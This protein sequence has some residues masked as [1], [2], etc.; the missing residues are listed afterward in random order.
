MQTVRRFLDGVW[1]FQFDP[2]G[3]A[4]FS[5]SDPWRPAIVPS[6][7]QAQFD[8]LRNATGAGWY[9][10]RFKAEEKVNPETAAAILHFGAVDY[11]ATVW[12]NGVLIGE[13]EGGY[14]P[15]EFD[16]AG[17]LRAGENQLL[18][19]VVDA[20]DDRT[21]YPD[22]PFSEVPHGK[23]SWY[24][25][26]GGIWQSVWLEIRPKVHI[27]QV[28]LTPSPATAEI[29]VQA[30][31]SDALPVDG[32]LAVI[33]NDPSG[34]VAG[35]AL[36]NANGSGTVTLTRTP[37]LWSIETPN[38]YTVDTVLSV[39]G[40]RRHAN[41][42]TCGFRTIEARDGRI[43]LNGN[44]IYLRGVLDQA[45]YPL[46]IYTPPN[47]EFLEDQVR[48]AKALG[49]NCLR[50]HIKIEDPRYYEVADRLGILIWTEIPNWVLLSPAA[51]HRIKATFRGMVERDWNHPSIIAWTLVNENWGTDLARNPEHRRW[52]VDFY[53]E[54]KAIDPTRLIIDNSACCDNFHVT[55]DL[56]DFHAYRAIPDHAAEWDQWV[57]ELASRENDWVWAPDFLQ[58]RRGS[59]VDCLG[60]WQL[61]IAKS[62]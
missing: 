29:A 2:T 7:W 40:E 9:H 33:V 11:H 23:Q 47:L 46:T 60:I 27:V 14:L 44:P 45:Y 34:A 35:E 41:R 54:A 43:Y 24:G 13:H 21:R 3:I 20:S 10:L 26:I 1:D 37:V 25:P 22:W 17:E 59:A 18:V 32:R 49:L 50:T 19:R 55:G 62:G 36:L 12:M 6:P 58:E 4:E 48:K 15:F 53:H 51:D 61:G 57:G 56:E 8:E 30:T 38:L 39:A 5:P 16:V 52:L 42:S 31:L 28:K